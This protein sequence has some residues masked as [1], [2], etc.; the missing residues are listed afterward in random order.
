MSENQ[1]NLR[2]AGKRLGWI[3]YVTKLQNY[4]TIAD[5]NLKT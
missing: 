2:T 1:L 3:K 4:S 5:H